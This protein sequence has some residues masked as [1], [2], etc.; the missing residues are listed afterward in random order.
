[1][2][3]ISVAVRKFKII[4]VPAMVCD[5]VFYE[6]VVGLQS[7]HIPVSTATLILGFLEEHMNQLLY[8]GN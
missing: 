3:D 1:M 8:S 6:A 4:I 7:I 2:D 5:A